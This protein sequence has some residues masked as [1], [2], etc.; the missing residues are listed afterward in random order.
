MLR[1]TFNKI[2]NY[3]YKTAIKEA[4][5]FTPIEV[6]I[7]AV[8]LGAVFGMAS[9]NLEQAK[10][11]QIPLAFS[12]ISQTEL[13][14]ETIGGQPVPPLTRFYSVT[15]DVVM[16]VFEANNI[17]RNNWHPAPDRFAYE[18]EK[19]VDQSMRIHTLIS[20]YAP[21]MAGW[22][23]AARQSIAP[24]T[25]AAND[26]APVVE[27]LDEAWD[28]DHR[29]VYRTE[30]YQEEECSGSGETESC[31]MVTKSREVYDYTIHTYTYDR[32]QGQLAATLLRDFMRE[33]PDIRIDE[34]FIRV[35]VTN[36][37]N[38]WAM[39]ESRRR[40]PGYEALTQE[41]YLRL[42]NVWADG[43]NVSVLTPKILENHGQLFR[44]G[45]AWIAAAPRARSDTYRTGN[46]SDSGPAAFQ[47]AEAALDYAVALRRDVGRIDGGMQFAGSQIP[48]LNQ[49]I[50][51]YVNAV[52]HG[53]EGDTKRL[54]REVMN[55]SREI[56]ARNYAGGFDT[57]PAKWGYVVL[58]AVLGMAAGGGL[59]FGADRLI[60]H[61][62]QRAG[63]ERPRPRWQ[64]RAP[65]V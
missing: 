60:T 11:G 29:D 31:S 34:R 37:E 10:R 24:M 26:L 22:T 36:A 42:T 44:A 41:D 40:L 27:A 48:V 30:Y 43:S 16:Q 1:D 33:H 39:R 46:R 51:Q 45:T 17:S 38:E 23:A 54:R 7:A 55:L 61:L 5:L 9:F 63:R 15:N 21:Q 19:K 4:V 64:K 49:K 62:Y 65:S 57:A 35:T 12:E 18:L 25:A 14:H 52:L 32:R 13:Y 2:K 50:V 8:A 28:D 56:Y 3:P 6:P 20:D 47:T 58:W 59:G 53:G